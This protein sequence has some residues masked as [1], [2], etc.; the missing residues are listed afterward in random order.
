M[1]HKKHLV[2]SLGLAGICFSA[3]GLLA[4]NSR[5]ASAEEVAP[6]VT[7]LTGA[8]VRKDGVTPGLKFSA[9]IENYNEQSQ[10]GM[11]ILPEEVM[12]KYSFD[13][14]YIARL[15]ADG[16]TG[17]Y[18]NRLCHPYS[19]GE[20]SWRISL[21]LVNILPQNYTQSFTGIAYELKDGVYSYAA[22]DRYN[23]SRSVSFV[24]Q[25]ALEYETELTEA[26][27]EN[28][29]AYANPGTEIEANEYIGGIDD[30]FTGENYTYIDYAAAIDI[31][32]L[33]ENAPMSM[34]TKKAYPGGSK[35]SFD[36]YKESGTDWCAICWTTDPSDVG[37]YKWTDSTHGQTLS[38]TDDTWTKCTVALP[39]DGNDYYVYFVGAKGEWG[40]K[41]LL[42]DNFSVG[43]ETDVFQSL[44]GGLFA[45]DGNVSL[46]QNGKAKAPVIPSVS[47]SDYCLMLDHEKQGENS[48]VYTARAYPAGTK[49]SFRYYFSEDA[50]I[51]W[52]RFS[53][54]DSQNIDIYSGNFKLLDVSEKGV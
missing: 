26:Q 36:A 41:K 44:G 46:V 19:V 16:K 49:V 8:S 29:N 31:D 13:N 51:G 15:E 25:L 48:R 34:I 39:D 24:A 22:I 17:K 38:L 10:Y 52:A 3:A 53:C 37:L 1:K 30:E 6:A 33:N 28:L 45:A 21:S 43:E 4:I 7:M 42:I 23:N 12:D 32:K 27:R 9:N 11:L 40:G 18:I 20:S 5:E 35:I 50:S 54:A 47:G 14:D 2:L